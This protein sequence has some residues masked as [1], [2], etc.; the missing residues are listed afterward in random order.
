MI[1]NVGESS[2]EEIT[3]DKGFYILHFQNES[4]EIQNFERE[5]NSTFIQIHFC[6]R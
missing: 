3:L 1:K 4:I 6:L 2:F 5:I